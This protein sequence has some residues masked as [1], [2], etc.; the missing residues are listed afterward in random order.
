MSQCNSIAET[1][2][3]KALESTRRRLV[4]I[5]EPYSYHEYADLITP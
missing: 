1:I 5:V 4:H 2:L 3:L